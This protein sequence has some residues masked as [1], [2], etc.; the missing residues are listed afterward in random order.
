[1]IFDMSLQSIYNESGTLMTDALIEVLLS[2]MD[3]VRALIN[4]ILTKINVKNIEKIIG[5]AKKELV[6]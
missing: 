5:S 2:S 3:I 4:H 1:M 6:E